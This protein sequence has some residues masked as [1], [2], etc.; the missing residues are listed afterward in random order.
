L[1]LESSSKLVAG[2]AACYVTVDLV[3]A[4][5]A[6]SRKATREATMGSAAGLAYQRSELLAEPDWLWERRDDP[7]VR[8][9]DCASLDAYGRAHIPGAAGLPVDVWIKEPEGG[10][11]VM[12]AE[13]FADLMSGLG[14]SDG[15]TVVTYDDFNTTFATRLW[16]VL[17]FY[18]HSEAR[19]LNGGWDRW[20]GESRPISREEVQPEP[21]LFTARTNE[22]VICR[23][24]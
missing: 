7:S 24:E 8:L 23:L 2:G 20:L 1:F 10:V 5:A 15:T 3:G 22:D 19:V 4:G 9:V 16:W 12:G 21:G 14:V 13:K 18:G 6:R 17:N 11:H